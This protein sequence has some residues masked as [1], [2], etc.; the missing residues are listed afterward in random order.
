MGG[1]KTLQEYRTSGMPKVAF[2]YGLYISSDA[3]ALYSIL[4]TRLNA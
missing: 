4:N 1:Y 2:Y 3:S